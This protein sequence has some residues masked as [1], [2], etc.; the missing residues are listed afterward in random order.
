MITGE[1]Q[2]LSALFPPTPKILGRKLLPYSVGHYCLLKQLGNVF[3]E[4]RDDIEG[5]DIAASALQAVAICSRKWLQA[6]SFINGRAMFLK[7]V[8]WGASFRKTDWEIVSKTIREYMI[9][10]CAFPDLKEPEGKPLYVGTPFIVRLAAWLQSSP[11]MGLTVSAAMDF[12]FNLAVRYFLAHEEAS[13]NVA[14][15]T[16]D[17]IDIA[18]EH[19]RLAKE[20]AISE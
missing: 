20:I 4:P 5:V 3:V 10:G 13:R 15:M 16:Q 17:E 6:Q 12:P 1:R 2:F 18:D 7:M 9:E 11:G 8:I 19:A 14:L